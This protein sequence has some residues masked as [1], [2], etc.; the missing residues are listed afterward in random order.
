MATPTPSDTL[1]EIESL[2]VQEGYTPSQISSYAAYYRAAVAKD[3]SITPFQAF[4]AWAVGTDVSGGAQATGTELSNVINTGIPAG[5]AAIPKVPAL[6]GID[7]IGAFFNALGD[8]NTWIRVSKV[9]V[10]GLLLVIGLVHITGA[11][12]AV[13]SLARK[14]PL[15]V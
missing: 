4:A 15:P 14:V 1:S 3:P 2:M 7:A 5:A 8:A 11:D 6:S 10:G 9:V 12:N 13:A